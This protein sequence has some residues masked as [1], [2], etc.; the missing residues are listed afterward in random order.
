MAPH[1]PLECLCCV[2]LFSLSSLVTVDPL[3]PPRMSA[4]R[5]NVTS[6]TFNGAETSSTVATPCGRGERHGS[7]SHKGL[8]DPVLPNSRAPRAAG[9]IQRVLYPSPDP[10][11]PGLTGDGSGTSWHRG[12][13]GVRPGTG[14]HWFPWKQSQLRPCGDCKRWLVVCE[15]ES[16][17]SVGL[18]P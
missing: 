9:R 13:F 6:R 12:A 3:T 14:C 1:H 7:R 8:D 16:L 11:L 4:C 18:F 2:S 17:Y 15:T 10:T 5:N